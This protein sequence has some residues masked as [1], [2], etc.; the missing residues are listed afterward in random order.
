MVIKCFNDKR[1][2]AKV[3]AEQAAAVLRQAIQD[4]EEPASLRPPAAQFEFLEALTGLPDIDWK[5]MEMF[6]LDEYIGLPASH[7]A[8]LPFPTGAPD[9]KRQELQVTSCSTENKVRPRSSAAPARLCGLR[10]HDRIFGPPFRSAAEFRHPGLSVLRLQSE[11]AKRRL[12]LFRTVREWGSNDDVEPF[13]CHQAM[14]GLRHVNVVK[15]KESASIRRGSQDRAHF[16]NLDTRLA[17]DLSLL[18]THLRIA[19][20]RIVHIV[21]HNDPRP[22]SLKPQAHGTQIAEILVSSIK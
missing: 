20:I 3:A 16:R 6:H 1:E 13:F 8:L 19:G 22:R 17:R 15:A 9:S 21:E 7:P 10:G 14:I 5:R 12:D 2:M 4:E 11:R 18:A